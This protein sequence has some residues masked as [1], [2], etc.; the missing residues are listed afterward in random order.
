MPGASGALGPGRGL[1]GRPGALAR[2]AAVADAERGGGGCRERAL[3]RGSGVRKAL[4]ALKAAFLTA[5]SALL[6]P[7][8]LFPGCA[9]RLGGRSTRFEGT[10]GSLFDAVVLPSR[11]TAPQHVLMTPTLDD[12]NRAL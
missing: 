12:M 5:E 2:C 1:S 4:G 3:G 11:C 7:K 10:R 8:P 6:G 9:Q